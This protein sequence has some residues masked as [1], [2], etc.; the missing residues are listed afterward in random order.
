L[1][2]V[3]HQGSQSIVVP[4]ANLVSG[5]CVIF[6]HNRDR[7]HFKKSVQGALSVLVMRPTAHIINSEQNLPN[8]EASFGESIGVAVNQEALP[9]TG[10]CLLRGQ[11]FGAFTQ[12][13]GC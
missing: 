1:Y 11:I 6:I 12:A 4:K 3:S 8:R 9:H 13:K 10:R 5:H 2:Q 7:T